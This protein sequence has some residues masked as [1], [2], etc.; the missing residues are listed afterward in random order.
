MRKIIFLALILFLPFVVSAQ[1]KPLTQAEYVKM[2]Y[3]LD[4]NPAMRDEVVETVRKRGISFQITD[5][6]R[7]L[8][9][10]K[11]R[12]DAELKRTLE[13][14]GRR[15]SNPTAYQLPAEKESAEVLAKAREA[16]LA[17]VE[18]MP[19]FVVKQQIQRG[20]SYAGTNNFRS[21]DRLVV[22]VSYRASSS[23]DGTQGNEEYRVLSKN[24]VLQTVSNVKGSYEE[25]GGTSSTGEFV[26]VLATI[27]KPESQTRFEPLDTDLIRGRRAIVYTFEADKDRAKQVITTSGTFSNSTI[28]G[29]KGKVWIDR[30]NFRV[31]RIESQATEIPEGF[32][33]TAASRNIDYDWVTISDEKYLLPSYSEVR[34]TSRENRN[35]YETRNQI[36][37]KEY[38][39]YGSEVKVLD[40]DETAIPAPEETKKP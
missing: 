30:E 31:L 23:E 7:S 26:T 5:G 6:L 3:A 22:A 39:K 21:L 25:V 33:V 14:A 20:A 4:K 13:E 27:F 19:D 12:G 35:A 11:S 36:R 16:T 28:T 37:F 8:T 17:A 2:L 32:P 34:L 18:E 9:S 40:D 29:I 24:G 10:N 1:D 38:Q 15:Q